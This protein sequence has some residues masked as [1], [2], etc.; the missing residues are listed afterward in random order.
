MKFHR[1]RAWR[2][3]IDQPRDTSIAG[4]ILA[5]KRAEE[6]RRRAKEAEEQANKVR[7]PSAKEGFLD[8]A[9]QW[10]EMAEQAERQGW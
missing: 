9:R 7:D 3:A 8:I 6:Y 5:M 2:V 10:R 4:S 1:N